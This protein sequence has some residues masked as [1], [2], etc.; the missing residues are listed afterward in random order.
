MTP[1]QLHRH[2]GRYPNQFFVEGAEFI[3]QTKQIIHPGPFEHE[4]LQLARTLLD[5]G[6][7]KMALF[8][9]HE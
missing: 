4:L 6:T 7:P 2:R 5:F 9:L 3:R 1:N 8:R